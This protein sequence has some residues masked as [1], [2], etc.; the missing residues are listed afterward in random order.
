MDRRKKNLPL[1]KE[2]YKYCNTCNMEKEYIS[3]QKDKAQKDGYKGR[4]TSCSKNRWNSLSEEDK[5][6]KRKMDRDSRIPR[7]EIIQERDRERHNTDKHNE[8]R[9]DANATRKMN[10]PKYAEQLK[11]SNK[12]WKEENPLYTR[13]YSRRYKLDHM[14]V[15]KGRVDYKL[16]LERDGYHCYICDCDILPH[17]SLAF[18]HMIPLHPRKGELKGE[19]VESNIH[20]THDVCNLRKAN[21]QFD[22]LTDWDKRGVE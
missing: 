20:P 7:K 1:A 8:K 13:E 2:G 6:V 16:I 4:C 19:H 11:E 14:A 10:D 21:K 15:R 18:D 22:N 9:R 3:F 12:R 17:Q 5:N